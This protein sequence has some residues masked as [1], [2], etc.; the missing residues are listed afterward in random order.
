[1]LYN[2]F[3]VEKKTPKIASSPWYFVNPP[4]EDGAMAIGN[5]HKKFGNVR[6]CHSRI[7]CADIHRHTHRR[8][9]R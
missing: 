5:M 3:L 9:R 8:A 4:E 1:M 2:A 6:M 7:I